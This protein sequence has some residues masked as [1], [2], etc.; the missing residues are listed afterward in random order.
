LKIAIFEP[1]FG[2]EQAYAPTYLVLLRRQ[3]QGL[4]DAGHEI[5]II[6]ESTLDSEGEKLNSR[7]IHYHHISGGFSRLRGVFSPASN[8][9][10]F[11][12]G[13]PARRITYSDLF[14]PSL[15][16][17]A[18]R[19]LRQISPDVLYGAGSESL[20]GILAILAKMAGVPS[21]FYVPAYRNIPWWRTEK[22]IF[23]GYDISPGSRTT[24]FLQDF[25]RY[26]A[27]SVL[28]D[29]ARRNHGKMVA[30][31]ISGKL[32][33]EK[34]GYDDVEVLYPIVDLPNGEITSTP[35]NVVCYLGHLYQGRGVLDLV[36]AL[37]SLKG[38]YPRIL[39]RLGVTNI[40]RTTLELFEDLIEKYELKRHIM[41]VGVV[42]DVYTEL[43]WNS[44]VV[45][46]PYRDQPSVKL[47]EAMASGRPV[48]TTGI[49][50]IKEIMTNGITGLLVA[51]GD[52]KGIAAALHKILSNPSS[53][54]EM[55]RRA[56]ERVS[57][58]CD[59]R[60]NTKKL[61]GILES[62]AR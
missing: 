56:V 4:F 8:R 32:E 24:T 40:D 60:R 20:C 10:D 6:T 22:D 37:E 17:I 45:V 54:A 9:D 36:K 35:E 53:S 61:I 3:V 57:A 48:V 5:E 41:D 13:T 2:L 16:P 23:E 59:R 38:Q 51:P 11:L 55:G 14:S 21:V 12:R 47:L 18:I 39:L 42:K 43:F 52:S 27:R 44:T 34:L 15:I 19:T 50:W 26:L 33:L 29:L 25:P 30:A 49:S 7:N 1:N 58:L 62:V 28:T 31:S 46:L